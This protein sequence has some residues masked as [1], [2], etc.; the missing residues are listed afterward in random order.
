MYLIPSLNQYSTPPIDHGSI[1]D[2]YTHMWDHCR[3]C[4]ILGGLDYRCWPSILALNSPMFVLGNMMITHQPNR[5]LPNNYIQPNN[6][7]IHIP[8]F[9][10][11][12]HIYIY[13][14]TIP[15]YAYIMGMYVPQCHSLI[16]LTIWSICYCSIKL[17]QSV[18]QMDMLS[19]H[20]PPLVSQDAELV[21]IRRMLHQKLHASGRRADAQQG[22][23]QAVGRIGIWTSSTIP[24]GNLT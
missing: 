7:A 4:L 21:D 8:K 10:L 17:H 2:L 22:M 5:A 18:R 9:N 19:P 14:A 11:Y 23:A 15:M 6:M 13:T 12:I 20:H 24:S 16:S 1:P 3:G